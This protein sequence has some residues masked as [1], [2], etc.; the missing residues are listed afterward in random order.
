MANIW[1]EKKKCPKPMIQAPVPSLTYSN[2]NLSKNL[3]IIS[4]SSFSNTY[5]KFLKNDNTFFPGLKI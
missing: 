5:F 3:Q 2:C 1:Q 4:L